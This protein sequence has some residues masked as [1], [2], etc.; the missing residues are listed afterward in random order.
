MLAI[1]LT[2]QSQDSTNVFVKTLH[3]I[4]SLV[5]ESLS[6]EGGIIP[7]PMFNPTMG[8]GIAVLPV[9]VY[10]LKGVH[11][12]TNPSTSQG[13]LF[14]NLAGNFLVGAKQ[15]LYFNRNK[16][17]LDVYAGYSSMNFK[18]FYNNGEDQEE[19][20]FDGF[21]SSMSFAFKVK[22]NFFIG[23]MMSN[24]YLREELPD[25]YNPLRVSEEYYW[26]HVP[27]V[28]LAFDSRDNLFY[29]ESGWF[30]TLTYETMIHNP[31]N[32]FN[33]DK[34]TFGLANY[35][36]ISQKRDM[37]IASRL[38]SQ[39]GMGLLPLHEMASPGASPVLRGYIT[40]NYLNSSMVTVQTELRWMYSEKW[41]CVGFM[42]YGW[43]FDEPR[44]ARDGITLPSIGAGIRYR[45]FPE[46]KINLGFDV[47]VGRDGSANV[48]LKMS[49]SF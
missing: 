31:A 48:Y 5:T 23:P 40:G 14:F 44:T 19:V 18:H 15:T 36:G 32:N 25:R 46:F 10:R 11:P 49:E 35:Q 1:S 38:F 27:G 39:L 30:N 7:A 41:G 2:A 20:Q 9:Y 47:A 12:E 29:P 6:S 3:S 13:I 43:L 17:W 4:D 37:L 45:I 34:V 33:F 42:G 21:I 16:Y 26:Y 8:T 24:N 28:K 22:N